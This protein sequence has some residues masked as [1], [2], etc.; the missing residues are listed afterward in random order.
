MLYLMIILLSFTESFIFNKKIRHNILKCKNSD[1]DI[2]DKF[3]IYS[4][5]GNKIMQEEYLS[6]IWSEI[7]R[8]KKLRLYIDEKFNATTNLNI[9]NCI[10][11]N[12][13]SCKKNN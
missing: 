3:E 13:N 4:L 2:Y 11:C 9:E 8:K 6:K 12:D 1:L 7:K 10:K 5:T